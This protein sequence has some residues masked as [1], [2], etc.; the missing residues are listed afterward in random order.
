M[1]SANSLEKLKAGGEGGKRWWDGWIAS[2]L[3]GHEVEQ[4]PGDGEGQGSMA[5][6]SPWGSKE[7]DTT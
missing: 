4:S 6:C 5:C 1:Q 7:S 3:N 2:W